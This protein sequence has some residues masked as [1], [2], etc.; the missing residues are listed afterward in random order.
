MLSFE[1]QYSHMKLYPEAA[2]VMG[3]MEA[4]FENNL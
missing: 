2:T 3:K 1:S 4:Y